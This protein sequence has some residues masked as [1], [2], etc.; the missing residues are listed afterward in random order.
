M[1]T[2]RKLA[3]F[4]QIDEDSLLTPRETSRASEPSQKGTTMRDIPDYERDAA[5]RLYLELCDM[6]DGL[7]Y[8]DPTFSMTCGLPTTKEGFRWLG[9]TRYPFQY[10]E[11]L[12]LSIRKAGF[13]LPRS[14]R[15]A[16]TELVNDAF[17]ENCGED[18]LLYFQ[19]DGYKEWLAKNSFEDND[20]SKEMYG[21]V[22]VRNIE[23][24]LDALFSDYMKD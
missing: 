24:Q 22:F 7:H 3:D 15:D 10:K 14:L 18:D 8:C 9:E 11:K 4:F 23:E 20:D 12:L 13:D 21:I 17:G 5:R 6:A 16:L 2:I 1:E 19:E